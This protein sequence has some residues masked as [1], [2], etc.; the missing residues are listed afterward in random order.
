M[1]RYTLQINIVYRYT[2]ADNII[3]FAEENI[4]N[5]FLYKLGRLLAF[6]NEVF[7]SYN[8]LLSFSPL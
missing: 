5:R 7:R 8:K 6:S 3:I 2:E 1:D 4:K